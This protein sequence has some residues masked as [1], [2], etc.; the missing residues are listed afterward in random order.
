MT[1]LTLLAL[2]AGL[3][4]APATSHAQ[5]AFGNSATVR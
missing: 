5:V 1:R 2:A 3:A 4:I